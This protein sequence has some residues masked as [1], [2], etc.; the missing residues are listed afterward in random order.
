MLYSISVCVSVYVSMC[1]S[2]V[3][4]MLIKFVLLIAQIVHR[5]EQHRETHVMHFWSVFAQK[6]Y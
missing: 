6:F 5:A 4:F 3:Y 2:H 1:A